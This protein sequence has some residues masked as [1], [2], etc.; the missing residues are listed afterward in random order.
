[1]QQSREQAKKDLYL[2]HCL[3]KDITQEIESLA[4]EKR[5]LE[6]GYNKLLDVLIPLQ[7]ED[8]EEKDS[9]WWKL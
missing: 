1:M 3:L 9:R 4:A 7:K 5:V 6:I 2:A 8:E